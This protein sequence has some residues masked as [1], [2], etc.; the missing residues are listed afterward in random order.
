MPH[1][2]KKDERSVATGAPSMFYS[3]SQKHLCGFVSLPLCVKFF[4]IGKAADEYQNITWKR[5]A[6]D[7]TPTAR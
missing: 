7:R 4:C 5:K 6:A 1:N 3:W 2:D